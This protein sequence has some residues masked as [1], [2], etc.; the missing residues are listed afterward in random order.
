MPNMSGARK[1]EQ[2][3]KE[4]FWVLDS[5][6]AEWGRHKTEAAA[7][8]D[9]REQAADDICGEPETFYVVEVVGKAEPDRKPVPVTYTDLRGRAKARAKR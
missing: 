8:K 2:R 7:V 9:A 6:G 5:S 3:M 4:R 1:E